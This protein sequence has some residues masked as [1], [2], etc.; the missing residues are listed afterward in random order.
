MVS[1]CG[2]LVFAVLAEPQAPGLSRADRGVLDAQLA[3]QVGAVGVQVVHRAVLQPVHGGI[4]IGLDLLGL[5]RLLGRLGCLAAGE[6]LGRDGL[7]LL[8][9]DGMPALKVVSGGTGRKEKEDDQGQNETAHG[10]LLSGDGTIVAQKP[11]KIK[12]V[13]KICGGY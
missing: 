9:G 10:S 4:E 2:L 1:P 6:H 7:Q 5:S 3:A 12:V 13:E 11:E 8:G